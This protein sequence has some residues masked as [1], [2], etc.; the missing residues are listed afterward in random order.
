M[1]I[2]KKTNSGLQSLPIDAMLMSQRKIFLCGEITQESA[3]I[4][5]KQLIYLETE[6]SDDPIDILITSSGGDVDSGLALHDQIKGMAGIPINMYCIGLAASMAAII[7]A[8]GQ[9][10]RR[11]ILPHSKVMLH[12]PHLAGRGITGSATSI[13]QTA[14]S[15]ML[16]KRVMS[17]IL[18]ED[19]GRSLREI[20]SAISYDHYLNANEAIKFGIVDDI[21]EKI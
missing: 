1:N 15:I 12:E 8:G 3:N 4:F 18:A 9:K 21:V 17:E 13:Q 19:C 11:F 5:L 7:L 16:T 14:E 20:S 6:G 10:G 2:I